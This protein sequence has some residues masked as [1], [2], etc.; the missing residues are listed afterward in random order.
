MQKR[1]DPLE[2][3]LL[4]IELLRR[5]PRKHKITASQLH[6]QLKDAG[7]DRDLR[8]VQRQL[9]AL[10]EHFDIERD[11]RSKPYGYRWLD[12]A[13]GLAVS[14]LTAQ[15]S[16]LLELAHQH[17]KNLLPPRLLS[18]MAGFFAQARRNLDDREQPHNA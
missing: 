5:I 1:S 7:F 4:A 15:E 18:S 16:L 12:Q 11:E 13:Q 2:T 10:S 17:L 6:Q 9:E 3:T 14:R 8:T